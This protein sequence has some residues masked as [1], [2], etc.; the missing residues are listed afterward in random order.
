MQFQFAIPKVI[1]ASEASKNVGQLALAQGC[2]KVLCIYDKGVKNAGIVDPVVKAMRD[3][4]LSV[5]EF[6]EVQPDPPIHIVE[7]AAAAARESGADCVVAIGGGS[8]LDTAKLAAALV[9]NTEPIQKYYELNSMKEPAL[10][11]FTIPTTSGTGSE[12][13]PAAVV[14]DPELGRKIT[15]VAPQLVP[16]CAVL[17]PTLTVGL[18]PAIT[19]A[20]GMDALS[21]AMESITCIRHN[22]LTDGIAL[23]AVRMIAKYLPVCVENGRDEDA[24]GHMMIAATM[25]GAAFGNTPT[26]VG[27]ACA[28]AMGARWHIPHGT[29]CALAL[30]FAMENCSR[31]AESQIALIADALKI[32]DDSLTPEEQARRVAIWVEQFGDSIGIP[33]LRELGADPADLDTIVEMSLNEKP[34]ILLSGEPVTREACRAYYER[35]FA[36]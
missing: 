31:V 25:A 2:Q 4:G 6:D 17:D 10:P 27:H 35:L 1:C 13:T 28:H 33:T 20:T 9:K 5:S 34:L 16:A 24:R 30:P 11:L 36:R 12:V 8:T 7:K 3:A 26:H 32:R 29:A 22:P 23:A 19:A 14:S 18:P 21:H 15:L